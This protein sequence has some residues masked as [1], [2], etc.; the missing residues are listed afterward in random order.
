MIYNSPIGPI[1]VEM[2]QGY[3]TKLDFGSAQDPG[4]EYPA[5]RQWLDAYFAGQAPTPLPVRPKGTAFQRRVWVILERIPYGQTMTYGQ[6]A[7]LLSGSMSAQAV[8]QAVG[9]N[10]VSIMIPCHRV[11][12]AGGRLTGYAGGLD[13]KRFLLDLEGIPYR[14]ELPVKI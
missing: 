4:P 12:G 13:K 1:I 6:I 14:T 7:R 10:P 2:E 11:L 8:G 3:V 5:V 9:K